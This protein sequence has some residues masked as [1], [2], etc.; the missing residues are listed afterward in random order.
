MSTSSGKRC[1]LSPRQRPH[2]RVN[3]SHWDNIPPTISDCFIYATVFETSTRSLTFLF[4]WSIKCSIGD[5][6]GL[7]GGQSRTATLSLVR[8]LRKTFA[9]RDVAFSCCNVRF[10]GRI[11]GTTWGWGTW[12]RKFTA[13]KLSW[14]MTMG[15]LA[16]REIPPQT[17]IFQHG[18]CKHVVF[19]LIWTAW[20]KTHH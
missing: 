16:P 3:C 2:Q 10:G 6:S 12:S 18:D 19:H 5:K 14:I 15:V 11:R 8:Q 17:K 4:A 13:I 20:S 7:F 9:T 1:F